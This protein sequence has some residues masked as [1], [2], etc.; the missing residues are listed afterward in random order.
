[1]QVLV[2][3]KQHQS[4]I[5]PAFSNRDI[6]ELIHGKKPPGSL[7][8]RWLAVKRMFRHSDTWSGSTHW[9]FAGGISFLL[10]IVAFVFYG[11][12]GIRPNIFPIQ[13]GAAAFLF[14][15]LLSKRSRETTLF[16]VSGVLAILAAAIVPV[17]VLSLYSSWYVATLFLPA[18]LAICGI[19]ALFRSDENLEQIYIVYKALSYLVATLLTGWLCFYAFTN[20]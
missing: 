9:N 1:M 19:A 20:L 12:T 4:D 15:F 16:K 7:N 10:I 6:Y 18:Q 14:L 2:F 13:L 17:L 5:A 3:K 11:D 8:K